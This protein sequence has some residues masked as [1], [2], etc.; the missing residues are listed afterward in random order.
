MLPNPAV[1]LSVDDPVETDGPDV[2]RLRK[3]QRDAVASR[4]MDDLVDVGGVYIMRG[5]GFSFDVAGADFSVFMDVIDSF[6]IAAAQDVRN[7]V[8]RMVVRIAGVGRGEFVERGLKRQAVDMVF[9]EFTG[10][11]FGVDGEFHFLGGIQ[12][13]K[14]AHPRKCIRSGKILLTIF[15]FLVK[16]LTKSTA[17]LQANRITD[18][19]LCLMNNREIHSEK[20]TLGSR[21]YFFDIK[22]SV[23]NDFYLL[24]SESRKTAN[25]NEHHRL[26]IFEE[27]I[28]PFSAL[29]K[30]SLIK[31]TELKE[32]DG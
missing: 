27:A 21:T 18:M 4:E 11:G 16:H 28:G 2:V 15:G 24:V 1:R 5:T 30:K 26:M 17:N 19:F 22:Q 25:G 12:S 9:P 3:H 13:A 7:K 32:G 6:G 23:R 14:I 10:A 31:F 20:I 29:L 8:K